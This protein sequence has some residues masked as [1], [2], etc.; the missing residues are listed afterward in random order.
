MATKSGKNKNSRARRVVKT[1]GTRQMP[2]KNKSSTTSKARPKLKTA[3]QSPSMPQAA[4][5]HG[6]QM[7]HM[8]CTQLLTNAETRRLLIDAAGEHA[9]HVIQEFTTEMSDE[10]IA[11]KAHIRSSDVRVVLNKLHSFGLATYSRSRDKNSGWYSYVWRLN[12]EHVPQMLG[13]MRSQTVGEQTV[14][15]EVVREVGGEAYFCK[16]CSPERKLPFE[17]ASNKMFKCDRCG[18][19]LE[20]FDQ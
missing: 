17:E 6:R 3:P 4:K 7:N 9:I 11:K 18:S 8:W 14:V 12:A 16:S 2:A 20:F 15:S 5:R 10:E 19:S 1:K 13:Q